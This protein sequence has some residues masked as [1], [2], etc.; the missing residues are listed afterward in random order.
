[1]MAER[2]RSQWVMAVALALAA[3]AGLMPRRPPMRLDAQAPEPESDMAAVVATAMHIT[4]VTQVCPATVEERLQLRSVQ[5]LQVDI[6]GDPRAAERRET[7]R[8]GIAIVGESYFDEQGL[9]SGGALMLGRAPDGGWDYW[10]AAQQYSRL[11]E[12]PHD[13]TICAG[14]EP[15]NVRMG[16]AADGPLIGRID[17]G[18]TVQVET[19]VLTEP[20]RY[21]GEYH[22]PWGQG[23][24]HI[25]SPVD[26]WVASRYVAT[27]APEWPQVCAFHDVAEQG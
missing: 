24:F 11:T 26:G 5:C 17:D 2:R 3:V 7:L 19:F 25:S 18:A 12:L 16:P 23:W 10:F 20:G 6:E 27:A 15:L 14:G 22:R 9:F 13:G 4:G 8:R 1:M 21:E